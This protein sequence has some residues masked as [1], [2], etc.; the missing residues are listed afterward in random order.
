[1]TELQNKQFLNALQENEDY[2]IR[3]A[4]AT[5]P[6]ELVSLLEEIG[7]TIPVQEAATYMAEAKAQL[8]ATELTD[9]MLDHVNGGSLT[10]A[11]LLTCAAYGAAVGVIAGLVVVGIYY[12]Y[13]KNM[14]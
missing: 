5:Q 6:E 11:Y 4:Q 13:R 1:M 10:I 2:A 3:V 8:E 9:E 14:R 12:A 7:I